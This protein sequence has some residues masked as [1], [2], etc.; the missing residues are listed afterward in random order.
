[1]G[2]TTDVGKLTVHIDGEN[3]I[4][5]DEFAIASE[6][7][8]FFVGIGPNLADKIPHTGI[9]CTTYLGPKLC[10]TFVWKP[11][12]YTEIKNHILAL[13]VKKACGYDNMSIRLI[14]DACD[15]ISTPLCHIFNM[16]LQEGKFPDALKIAKVTPIYKKGPKDAPG[17]YRPISVL[18]VIGKIFEKIVN[19]Q[20]ME[21]L[22][23]NN[24]QHQ[25]QYGFRKKIQYKV[26]CCKCM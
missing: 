26:I 6:F 20:L 10:K 1:M 22:E 25:H 8:N 21:F 9:D 23:V 13:D 7:N 16:S 2:K 17:N 5:T 11:I 19:K 4:I 24:V 18:P 12:T 14:K 3:R 15:F